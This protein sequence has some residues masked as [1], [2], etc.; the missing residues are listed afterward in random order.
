MSHNHHKSHAINY[1]ILSHHHHLN[2]GGG[3]TEK[4]TDALSKGDLDTME[5]E[6][7]YSFTLYAI[8]CTLLGNIPG[9]IFTL[10]IWND[11]TFIIS[12]NLLEAFVK[13]LASGYFIFILPNQLNWI[14]PHTVEECIATYGE[15]CDKAISV[16]SGWTRFKILRFATYRL[17]GETIAI[18][19]SWL[20]GGLLLWYLIGS[21]AQI[22]EV[23]FIDTGLY[24]RTALAVFFAG[25]SGVFLWIAFNRTNLEG[26][27]PA[28]KVWHKKTFTDK[29]IA[30]T[31]ERQKRIQQDKDANLNLCL[32]FI[33]AYTWLSYYTTGALPLLGPVWALGML[34]NSNAGTG[35]MTLYL[36]I[37]IGVVLVLK[38]PILSCA[39]YFGKHMTF[40]NTYG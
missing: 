24:N 30:A 15:I 39:R 36:M 11:Q 31:P 8:V 32:W 20:I 35:W 19:S 28:E 17:I 29:E 27:P 5:F 33:F 26:P 34:S 2:G 14:I 7:T 4:N 16:H 18:V 22:G 37:G 23:N 6:S 12:D 13:A 40:A 10:L 1:P 21:R 3:S 9:A 38:T 25:F